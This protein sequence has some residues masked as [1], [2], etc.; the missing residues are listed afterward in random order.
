MYFDDSDAQWRVVR[1]NIPILILLAIGHLLLVYIVQHHSPKVPSYVSTSSINNSIFSTPPSTPVPANLPSVSTTAS[2]SAVSPTQSERRENQYTVS[3]PPSNH[4]NSPPVL[5]TFH[6]I[7]IEF[8]DPQSDL[9]DVPTDV[10]IAEIADRYGS[11]IDSCSVNRKCVVHFLVGLALIS[12]LHQ[13]GALFF[14]FFVVGNFAVVSLLVYPTS[15]FALDQWKRNVCLPIYTWAFSIGI[16]FANEYWDG[17]RFGW[18]SSSLAFLDQYQGIYRWTNP[19]NFASLRIISFNFDLLWALQGRSSKRR[20]NYRA[21]SPTPD[22]NQ[23]SVE[24]DQHKSSHSVE[25]TRSRSNSSAHHFGQLNGRNN[26]KR[27]TGKA[28]DIGRDMGKDLGKDFGCADRC[29]KE[30]RNTF[31]YIESITE[32]RA[33]A[34]LS[35]YLDCQESHQKLEEYNLHRYLT[36]MVYAPLYLAG[37]ICSFNAWSSQMSLRRTKHGTK[38]LVIYGLLWVKNLI[39]MEVFTHLIYT[40]GRNCHD[41]IKIELNW[42]GDLIK[43]DSFICNRFRTS[44]WFNPLFQNIFYSVSSW[45]ECMNTFQ[46]YILLGPLSR[47][48]IITWLVILITFL[49]ILT[50]KNNRPL[51]ESFPI[52]VVGMMSLLALF[53]LWMKLLLTWRFFRLWALCDGVDVP[54]NMTRCVFNNYT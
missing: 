47:H 22:S 4:S 36:Y 9:R 10:P 2:S 7:P 33:H 39:V 51:W 3:P 32:S 21:V 31:D 37:P 26:E 48:T 24:G 27:E 40:T 20:S 35:H 53:H 16:L 11:V 30:L 46:N 15:S 41:L 54:E 34:E 43:E 50:I 12:V 45:A 25:R 23:L 6:D 38:R 28:R 5:K 19:F 1:S 29:I 49:A 8:H 42:I 13:S 52:I 17:Y 44:I 14:F 18:I